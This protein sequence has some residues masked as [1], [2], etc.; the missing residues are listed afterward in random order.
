MWEK[1]SSSQQ[2]NKINTNTQQKKYKTSCGEEDSSS[3]RVDRS[4]TTA[5]KEKLLAQSR[6]KQ[7]DRKEEVPAQCRAK[8]E[9]S[10]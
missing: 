3:H 6:A 9:E 10:S 4:K 8:Q 5:R 2:G 7:D 1:D